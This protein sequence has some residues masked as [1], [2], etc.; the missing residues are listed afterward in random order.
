MRIFSAILLISSLTTSYAEAMD[1]PKQDQTSPQ[2]ISQQELEIS[3]PFKWQNDRQYNETMAVFYNLS[4]RDF[5]SITDSLIRRTE[6]SEDIFQWYYDSMIAH[7]RTT[8]YEAMIYHILTEDNFKKSQESSSQDEKSKEGRGL[9][10]EQDKTN[11]KESI[12]WES[13]TIKQKLGL[14]IKDDDDFN[15]DLININAIEHFLKNHLKNVKGETDY[16]W[17]IDEIVEEDL[18]TSADITEDIYQGIKIPQEILSSIIDNLCFNFNW[19]RFDIKDPSYIQNTYIQ[20]L[21]DIQSVKEFDLIKESII[22]SI[23]AMFTFNAKDF[24]VPF[25]RIKERYNNHIRN[26][27]WKDA[28]IEWS[29][30]STYRKVFAHPSKR[31]KVHTYESASPAFPVVKTFNR[32]EYL[33]QRLEAARTRAYETY[34]KVYPHPNT[35]K[36][37][38]Y[39]LDSKKRA[40]LSIK[41]HLIYPKKVG[42]FL[43]DHRT[44]NKENVFVPHFYFIVSSAPNCAFFDDEPNFCY[45]PLKFDDLPKCPLTRDRKDGLFN[46]ISNEEYFEQVKKDVVKGSILQ[47]KEEEE[48]KRKIETVIKNLA[49]RDSE[50][51]HSERGLMQ[52]L[53]DQQKVGSICE[54]LASLLESERGKGF[55]N[56]Y[57]AVML[58]YSTN[59]VCKYCTPTLIALQNSHEPGEFLSTLTQ[60][61]IST[62]GPVTFKVRGYDRSSGKMNWTQFRL[63]TFVTA[64]INFDSQAHDLT[65]TGEHSHGQVKSPP[66]KTHNPY[67]KL[68]FPHDEIDISEPAL[69][70][71]GSPDPH[72]RF[73][74]EFVGKNMH[75]DARKKKLPLNE[76]DQLIYLPVVFS[77]GSQGWGE[78]AMDNNLPQ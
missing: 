38:F 3:D 44:R 1:P 14:T 27:K 19:E 76:K 11:T 72:Q 47:G 28:L 64:S 7:L 9:P 30:Y 6:A 15:I 57:G 41:E 59:S 74:Y 20:T 4:E 10:D 65:D 35:R 22:N 12:K 69:L 45:I 2:K 36:I 66:K 26:R 63:N 77:S 67:A 29:I 71:N 17:L 18:L 58:A 46:S 61:L 33:I 13:Y 39:N 55:Y 32:E 52:L 37:I 78:N 53:R 54:R 25:D 70:E 49:G 73:F 23:H 75:S 60:K 5:N 16:N 56:V 42:K 43:E 40:T 34:T 21:R 31:S 8:I 51:V 68:F 62:T 24:E 50:L 48:V